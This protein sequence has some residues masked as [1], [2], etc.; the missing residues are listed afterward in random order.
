MKKIPE[1]IREEL[2]T[3][4]N[5]RG[6]D[7]FAYAKDTAGVK[8]FTNLKN[9]FAKSKMTDEKEINDALAFAS[10][11]DPITKDFIENQFPLMNEKLV[12]VLVDYHKAFQVFREELKDLSK[13]M[14][15]QLRL[16]SF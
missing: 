9:Q 14:N 5:V 2:K 6:C 13:Y 12:S 11:S 10:T 15:E 16:Q 1:P 3:K 4:L 8:I 7:Y